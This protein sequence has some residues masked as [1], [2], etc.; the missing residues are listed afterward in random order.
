VSMALH[1]PVGHQNVVGS[2]L[3]LVYM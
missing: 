2:W 3:V 1:I